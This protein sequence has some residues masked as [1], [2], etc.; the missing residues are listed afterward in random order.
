MTQHL[1]LHQFRVGKVIP[2]STLTELS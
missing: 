2:D 1:A